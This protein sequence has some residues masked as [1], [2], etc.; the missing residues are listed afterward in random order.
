MQDLEILRKAGC[1]PDV[2]AH[3]VKVAHLAHSLADRLTVPVDR[4]LTRLG[5]LFHDI[6][7]SKTHGIEHALV[8]VECE[9][10]RIFHGARQYHR[11]PYRSRHDFIGGGPAGT[12]GERLPAGDVEE[13]IVSYAVTI[14]SAGRE[15]CC[16]M[17]R[18]TVS[19][20]SW[21]PDHE[22]VELFKKQHHEI[23]GWMK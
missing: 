5:G 10:S 17:K 11:A 16:F 14:S 19:R 21:G 23:Q 15:R 1:S 12:S 4:E 13:K 20:T 9:E 22:G 6:G 3:C 2:V 7:R 18:S 8:G